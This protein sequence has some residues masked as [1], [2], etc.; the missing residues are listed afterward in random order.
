MGGWSA[1]CERDK[2][3]TSQGRIATIVDHG[4]AQ[5]EYSCWWTSA[6]QSFMGTW[7]Q[8]P[9]NNGNKPFPA[10]REVPEIV[11]KFPKPTV[12]RAVAICARNLP[13]QV[14]FLADDSDDGPT[15][16][17][18]PDGDH[19]PGV[20]QPHIWSE[21]YLRMANEELPFGQAPPAEAY[22]RF[23]RL[24]SVFQQPLECQE[25]RLQLLS[26]HEGGWVGTTT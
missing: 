26:C 6:Y 24:P 11:V 18:R 23:P 12:L 17:F 20:Q 13:R 1:H 3:R 2:T 9:A 16:E 8:L 14:R 25:L 5:T 15:L 21:E 22:A 10:R 4:Q 7:V 19:P